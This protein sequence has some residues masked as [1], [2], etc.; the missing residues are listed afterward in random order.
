M[1]STLILFIFSVILLISC[2]CK[3]SDEAAPPNNTSIT[4]DSLPANDTLNSGMEYWTKTI[5]NNVT[6]EEPSG[7]WTSL[8]S[9]AKLGG[10][11]TVSKTTDKH[12]G[13]YAVK[14]ESVLWGSDTS[15]SS[16]LIPGLLA[17][18]KFITSDPF[19][20]QGKPF[21]SKPLKLQ[22]YFKYNS[23]NNDSAVIYAKLSK[24]SDIKGYSDTIAEASFVIKNS[25]SNYQLLDI[26]FN[27]YINNLTPDSVSIVFVSSGDGRNFKGQVGSTL[28]IDDIKFVYSNKK[29]IKLDF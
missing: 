6:Y 9:L 17:V 29:K 5:Q 10:P 14:L 18:G 23:V 12:S 25:I 8:N 3:K 20:L 13:N 2:S 27:Y 22:G 11:V 28:Y 1:K 19:I 15:S 26:P 16:L 4:N 7:W 24:Y 21:T